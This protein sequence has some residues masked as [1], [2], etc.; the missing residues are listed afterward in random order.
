MAE[1]QSHVT[2]PIAAADL[3]ETCHHFAA[4]GPEA[5]VPC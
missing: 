2:K 1:T 3:K 4:N 5:D